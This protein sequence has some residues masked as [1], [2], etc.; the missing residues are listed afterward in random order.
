MICTT[1]GM[2]VCEVLSF[3]FMLPCTMCISLFVITAG[4]NVPWWPELYTILWFKYFRW[5]N[6]FINRPHSTKL[7]IGM[8]EELWSP[9]SKDRLC[10]DRAKIRTIQ[11]TIAANVNAEIN[12]MAITI[13]AYWKRFFQAKYINKTYMYFNLLLIISAAD[14]KNNNNKK[15]HIFHVKFS[16]L[17]C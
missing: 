14:K 6:V 1:S 4:L 11:D 8:L 3:V 15:I 2:V 17:F 13:S 9:T 16:C 12:K 10:A 5:Q 7:A